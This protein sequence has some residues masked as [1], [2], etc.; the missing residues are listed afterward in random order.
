MAHRLSLPDPGRR[1]P[2]APWEPEQYLAAAM[3]ERAAFL[4]R[5][6]QYR[7]LQDEIDLMLD[8]AGSAENRMAVLALLMEG[9]LLELQ[10]QLQRLQRLC[11]DHLGRA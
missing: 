2:K 10:G 3:R 6:P 7:S 9:K 1:T 11:R 4:E 8:K 5:H